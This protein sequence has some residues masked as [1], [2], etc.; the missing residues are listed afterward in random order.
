MADS[1][2]REMQGEP[3]IACGR[4]KKLLNDEDMSKEHWMDFPGGP[5][6]AKPL[7]SARDTDSPGHRTKIPHA[8]GG[9]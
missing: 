5:V 6:V 1:R 7:F 9:N 3:E 2:L 4:N 8:L